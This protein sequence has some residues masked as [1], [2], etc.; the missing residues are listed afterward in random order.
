MYYNVYSKQYTERTKM[1][2]KI[3]AFVLIMFFAMLYVTE[4]RQTRTLRD[5]MRAQ[6]EL[7]RTQ[8]ELIEVQKSNLEMSI[9]LLNRS[10]ESLDRP[11]ATLRD[12]ALSYR[13]CFVN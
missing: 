2:K 7:I 12:G 5:Y 8:G 9:E 13:K 6:S 4:R 3:L 10:R 1:E 11:P